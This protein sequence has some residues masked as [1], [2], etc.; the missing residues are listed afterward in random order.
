[1]LAELICMMISFALC[2]YAAFNAW[3]VFAITTGFGGKAEWPI[4]VIALSICAIS[5][6]GVYYFCP[7][8]ISIKETK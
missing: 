4:I 8:D 5:A 3:V 6:Y 2:I 7:F 1:M